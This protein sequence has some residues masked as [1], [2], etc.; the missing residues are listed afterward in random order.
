M[1]WTKIYLIRLDPFTFSSLQRHDFWSKRK[2]FE[3]AKFTSATGML[4]VVLQ[5]G[6]I[7]I[8]FG[9]LLLSA[10]LPC[11]TRNHDMW[12][13][14]LLM[15][16]IES[17]LVLNSHLFSILMHMIP[18]LLFCQGVGYPL[19]IV[20]CSALGAD[21]YDCVYP[22]RTARFG[23]ALIPEVTHSFRKWHLL[24]FVWRLSWSSNF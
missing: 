8:H 1:T 11:L 24:G 14:I 7:K 19:D 21:M 2:Y 17:P 5:V 18:W 13:Y 6:K 20:V 15:Q 9:G 3:I 16:M 12:W 4:S 23:T 22:T 10:L